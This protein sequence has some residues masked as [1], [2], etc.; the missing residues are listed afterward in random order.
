MRLEQSHEEIDE[1]RGVRP[2]ELTGSNSRTFLVT[3]ALGAIGTWTIRRL[4]DRGHRAVALDLGGDAH[5]LAIALTPTEIASVVR[6]NGDITDLATVEA[7]MSTHDIDGVIHLAAFQVPMVRENPALGAHVNVVGT[8]NVLEA[9]RRHGDIGPVVYASSIAAYGP[10]GT[11]GGDDPPQTLYGVFKRAN[12]TTAVRYYEDFGVASIGLRPHTVYGPARDQGITSA[13]TLAMVAA[14]AGVPYRIPFNA[15][16]QLQYAPDVG[17][18]FARAA[19]LE[20]EGAAVHNL[21]GEVVGM[22]TFREM[23]AAVIPQAGA[24][25]TIDNVD[26]PLVEGVDGTSFIEILGASVMRPV[27]DGVRDALGRFEQ[28]LAQGLVK[29]PASI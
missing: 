4:L 14:A 11:L 27:A 24:L 17:E 15:R 19:L 7:A 12:E 20:Y 3:G 16:L 8:V 28:L 22:E 23:I 18:A 13:P 26:L 1:A 2:A 29:A 9:V 21:D 25:I 5:R 10:A 6:I